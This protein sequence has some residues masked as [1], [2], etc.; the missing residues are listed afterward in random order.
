MAFASLDAADDNEPL[1]DINMVPLIDVMLVL[2]IIFMVTAPLLTHAV[3]IDL[4]QASSQPNQT[5]PD[6]IELA[7]DAA[8]VLFWNGGP[9]PRAELNA[10]LAQAAQQQPKPELHLRADRT[11]QYQTIAEVM[12]AAARVGVTKIGFVTEPDT[13]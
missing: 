4:P 6:K 1:A 7:I 12:S 9:L 8:G 13:R 3:K 5:K 11:T 10:R 2:L